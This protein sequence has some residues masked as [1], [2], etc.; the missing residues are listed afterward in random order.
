MLQSELRFA[1]R[2][3]TGGLERF[4]QG[5]R[6]RLEAGFR[7][8]IF[9]VDVVRRFFAAGSNARKNF[10]QMRLVPFDALVD[11]DAHVEI[12][13]DDV[14]C[15]GI[16]AFSEQLGLGQ[17]GITCRQRLG[18]FGLGRLDAASNSGKQANQFID[19]GDWQGG[20]VPLGY[21]VRDR[22]LLIVEP[23]AS[24]I[25]RIFQRF[26]ELRSVTELCRELTL[27]GMT[28]KPTR[29]KDGRERN[30]TPM[31]RKYLAKVLRNPL[32][33][34]EIRHKGSAFAGQHEPIISRQLWDRVQTILAG[35]ASERAGETRTRGKT[36]ALLR[37]LLYDRNGTKYHITFSRKPSG[38]QYRYYI[39]KNDVRYGHHSGATG[40]IPADQIEEV[41]INLV[42]Q[43][44]QTP[45]AVQSIWNQ[46]HQMYPGID[47]PT[48]VLAM[49]RL[50]N[51]WKQL[52]P[53]EQIR[54]VNLLIERVVLLSDGIDIVWREVGWKDLAG[55][56]APESIGAEMLEMEVAA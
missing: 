19:G 50:A 17:L 55:E 54:L 5:F 53:E 13:I 20:Y 39:P 21:E 27:D 18:D 49:R 2:D 6:P 24:I 46:T 10:C 32:Y 3:G 14:G 9:E 23:E 33:V 31:D 22:K 34:G 41:V 35:D 38:K 42:L 16:L 29:L 26:A 43:A 30:G 40:M 4:S 1:R 28:T 48:V 8:A 25:R 15:T 7:D 11:L 36:D 47:E 44:L 37:G 12:A 56:L 51:V 52:F 45:E